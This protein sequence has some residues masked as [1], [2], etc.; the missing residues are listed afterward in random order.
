[1]TTLGERKAQL[2]AR[3]SE[4]Q[5][6]LEGIEAELDSHQNPDWDDLAA[7]READEV[8]EGLGLSGQQEIRRIAAALAR[9]EA[10]GYG[11]CA[12]CGT[13]IAEARLDV[14]PEAALCQ[15]CAGAGR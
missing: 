12:H 11:T 10:G 5:A 15:A 4:L 6:R 2:Q 9:I 13:D 3:Q 8:L 1:M 7:E 14:M